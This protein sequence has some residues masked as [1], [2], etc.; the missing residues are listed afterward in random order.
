MDEEDVG[1]G[2]TDKS[3]SEQVSAR[4]IYCTICGRTYHNKSSG[5]PLN[6]PLNI[7]TR[8]SSMTS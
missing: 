3:S 7:A 4:M 8:K 5:F 1:K 2:I 6:P